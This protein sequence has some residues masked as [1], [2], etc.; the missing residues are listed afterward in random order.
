M[1]KTKQEVKEELAKLQ[2]LL[3]EVRTYVPRT[4]FGDSNV[5]YIK[6]EIKAL[7]RGWDEDDA[8][9]YFDDDDDRR[10]LD[11]ALSAIQW[12][13]GTAEDNEVPSDGWKSLIE[14]R[15]ERA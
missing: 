12:R 8:Y 7:E 3:P 2:A 13:D 4:G 6:A 5:D 14:Y 11:G 15:K 1:E 10:K 9:D